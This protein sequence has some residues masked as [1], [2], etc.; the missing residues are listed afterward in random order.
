MWLCRYPR[1]T[2]IMYD[3]GK[4]SL[5]HALINDL[6]DNEYRIKAKC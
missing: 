2:I 3:H 6:I 1:P 5:G 4:E